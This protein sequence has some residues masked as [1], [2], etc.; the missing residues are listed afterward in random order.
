[1]S[2]QVSAAIDLY[3]IGA[4]KSRTPENVA[5]MFR[6]FDDLEGE[7]HDVNLLIASKPPAA[8]PLEAAP[9]RMIPVNPRQN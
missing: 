2:R 4:G 8:F 1:M 6:I 7:G 5:L 3:L 9:I